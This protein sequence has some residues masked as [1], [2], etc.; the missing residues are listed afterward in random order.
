MTTK[1]AFSPVAVQGPPRW[2]PAPNVYK[3]RPAL[4]GPGLGQYGPLGVDYPLIELAI[5]SGAF[6]LAWTAIPKVSGTLKYLAW[7]VLI[8]SGLRGLNDL[9]KTFALLFGEKR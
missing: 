6:V 4:G 9:A 7:G 2:S 5:D 1:G 3:P 8:L